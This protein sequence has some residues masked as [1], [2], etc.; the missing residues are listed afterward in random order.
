MS[1]DRIEKKVLL[2]APRSRVWR[3][4]TDSGEFGSWFG[5]KFPGPFVAGGTMRGVIVG[6]TVN[7]EIAK[8][9][10]AFAD[11][12][13]EI[14]VERIEPE[15]LFAFRW[16]PYACDLSADYSGEP[17][18]LV[19]FTLQEETEGVL[20]TVVESGFDQIPLERRAQAFAAN[21]GGWAVQV[22]L[23]EAYL[24]ANG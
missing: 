13:F 5:V 15:R 22:T 8:A 19:T 10:E 7:E 23:I 1:T 21:E 3:A 4:L 14:V 24:A 16:H 2:R 18:T 17:M 20:L 12:W 11:V 6:T 9:Q